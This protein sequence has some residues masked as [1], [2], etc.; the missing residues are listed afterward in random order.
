MFSLYY[1]KKTK[2][3]TNYFI[4]YKIAYV[5]FFLMTFH[6]FYSLVDITSSATPRLTPCHDVKHRTTTSSVMPRHRAS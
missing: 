3:C 2:F 4:L 1:I 6:F 5:K